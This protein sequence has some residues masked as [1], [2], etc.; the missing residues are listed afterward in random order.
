MVRG[1]AALPEDPAL[2]PTSTGRLSISPPGDPTPLL[3][4]SGD[5]IQ[6]KHPYT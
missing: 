3:V 6:T 4:S 1:L 2:I 5:Y